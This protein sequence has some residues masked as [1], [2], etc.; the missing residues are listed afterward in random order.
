MSIVAGIAAGPPVLGLIVIFL[1]AAI[2]A[3]SHRK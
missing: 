3:A 2:C 1:I